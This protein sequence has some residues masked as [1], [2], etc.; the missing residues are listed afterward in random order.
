MLLGIVYITVEVREQFLGASSAAC[1]LW[2]QISLVS[3]SVLHTYQDF[4]TPSPVLRI[5]NILRFW[6]T[7]R[8]IA[9]H[10]T[11]ASVCMRL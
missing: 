9:V 1:T 10:L 4:L 2:I 11:L 5:I 8:G 7:V 3:A 6:I